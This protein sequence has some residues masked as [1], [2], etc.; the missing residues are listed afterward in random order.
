MLARTNYTLTVNG[1]RD[2]AN[3]P[4]VIAPGTQWTF[5]LNTV[6]LDISFVRPNVEPIGPATR[7]GPLVI[8]EIMYHPAARADGKSLEF[9]EL[10]NSN[11]FFEDVSGYRI[12]GQVDFTFPSNTVLQARS[13]LVVAAA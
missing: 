3:T 1:V 9:L 7:H 11:P 2:R 4:N 8:S 12:S 13:Y 5:T 6:P 10:Y